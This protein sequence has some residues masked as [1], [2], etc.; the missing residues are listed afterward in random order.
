MM[1]FR[2]LSDMKCIVCYLNVQKFN[3]LWNICWYMKKP[4]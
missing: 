2:S 1:D 4:L 3:L